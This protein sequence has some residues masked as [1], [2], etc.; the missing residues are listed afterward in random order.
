[1]TS[2]ACRPECSSLNES[3]ALS[4]AWAHELTAWQQTATHLAMAENDRVR[5][6]CRWDP[7]ATPTWSPVLAI[8]LPVG[9]SFRLRLEGGQQARPHGCTAPG[10]RKSP[11]GRRG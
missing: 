6:G 7:S 3:A 11:A 9:M 5:V 10:Y 8:R 1:M 2:S 4:G